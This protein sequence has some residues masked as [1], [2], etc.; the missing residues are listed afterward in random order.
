MI[1]ES[2]LLY[3]VVIVVLLVF[4]VRNQGAAAYV[5][6]LAIAIRVRL[7]CFPFYLP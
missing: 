7:I 3:T 5:E 1:V 6:E 4:E 2:A